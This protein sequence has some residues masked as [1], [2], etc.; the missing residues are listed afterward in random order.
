MG[1][2][3]SK[4]G[5]VQSPPAAMSANQAVSAAKTNGNVQMHDVHDASG[6]LVASFSNIVTARAEARRVGGTVVP[7][8]SGTVS[9]TNTKEEATNG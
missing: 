1:C 7:R 5:T 4:R 2:G 3:C 8:S 6:A 9:A